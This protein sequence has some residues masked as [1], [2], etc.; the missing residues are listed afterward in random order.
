MR[1]TMLNEPKM[2]IDEL[3]EKLRSSDRPVYLGPSDRPIAVVHPIKRDLEPEQRKA[4]RAMKDLLQKLQILEEK[5][6]MD[7]A[8][9]FYRFENALIEETPDYVS[10]WVS[11]SAFASTLQRY[12][13]TRS[14]V[15]CLL[16]EDSVTTT[17]NSEP[18]WP[19]RQ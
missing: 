14:D 10:W 5:Y 6:Q 12:N 1:T 2:T 11:Y 9:F 4:V 17:G 18:S 19:Q 15:E 16:M 8:D 3:M 13:L 7:S